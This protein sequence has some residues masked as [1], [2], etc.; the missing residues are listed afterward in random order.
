MEP[1]LYKVHIC[2][3]GDPTSQDAQLYVTSPPKHPPT[4]AGSPWPKLSP[5]DSSIGETQPAE[6][7]INRARVDIHKRRLLPRSYAFAP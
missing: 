6:S 3:T 1:V 4:D 7:H 5:R 2:L